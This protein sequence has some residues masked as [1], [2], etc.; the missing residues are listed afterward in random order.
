M[1]ERSGLKVRV[2]YVQG[3]LCY[4]EAG[5]GG[6]TAAAMEAIACYC[7]IERGLSKKK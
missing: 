6:P 1:L 7:L 2:L 3:R 5:M 4:I